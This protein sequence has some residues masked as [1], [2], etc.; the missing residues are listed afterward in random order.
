MRTSKALDIARQ[1]GGIVGD[2]H[3]AWVID[4]M[5]R[6]LT[7]DGYAMFVADAKAGKDGP[8]TYDW[9]EGIAP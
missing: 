3:R 5:V 9:D 2:H 7:G 1:Y 6:A 8:E 4:Q